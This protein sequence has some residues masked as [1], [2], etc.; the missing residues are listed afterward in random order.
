MFLH[1]DFLYM[2][3]KTIEKILL[4]MVLGYTNNVAG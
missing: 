4:A 1:N 2:M 3:N